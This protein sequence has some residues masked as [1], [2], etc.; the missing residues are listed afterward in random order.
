MNANDKE[1][2][3]EY[4]PNKLLIGSVQVSDERYIKKHWDYIV[5]CCIEKI[6]ESVPVSHFEQGMVVL[7]LFEKN[8][9]R[10]YFIPQTELLI[11]YLSCDKSDVIWESVYPHQENSIG[12]KSKAWEVQGHKWVTDLS[13]MIIGGKGMGQVR[14]IRNVEVYFDILPDET[15]RIQCDIINYREQF[16]KYLIGGK[17][18]T[19]G[20]DAA[21][22]RPED[23]QA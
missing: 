4:Y 22:S 11:E 14:F 18:P 12:R 13:V 5:W 16:E 6:K 8:T 10:S 15:S 7:R 20:S 3:I 21:E 2:R 1:Y 23:S 9:I 17:L 19:E